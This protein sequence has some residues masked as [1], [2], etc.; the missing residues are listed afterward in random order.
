MTLHVDDV[1]P[2]M[3]SKLSSL[4]TD[5]CIPL[6]P[7]IKILWGDTRAIRWAPDALNY[8]TQWHQTY[9]THICTI[10]KIVSMSI[11][12]VSDNGVT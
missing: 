1:L 6:T 12:N 5:H 3:C 7:E 2:Q 10:N 4:F 9:G 8:F 11:P